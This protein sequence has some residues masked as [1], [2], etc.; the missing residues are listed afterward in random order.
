M[1][2]PFEKSDD[3]HYNKDSIV[4]QKEKRRIQ[5]M[6]P[7]NKKRYHLIDSIRGLTLVS[8]ILYHAVWNLVYLYGHNWY[9][10]QSEIGY[11]WQ[12][13]ICYTLI[14]FSGFCWS[15]GKH[16]LKRG[17]EVLLCG[18]L[19]TAVTLL[20]MPENRVVFGVLTLIGSCMIL[21]CPLHKLFCKLPAAFGFFCSLLL[22]VLLRNVNGGFLGFEGWNL[23]P[24]PQQM[25]TGMVS[26]YFGFPHARFFSTDYFSLFPWFFLYCTG[27]FSFQLAARHDLLRYFEAPRC[28][29]AEWIG[30]H[31]LELYLLHQPV[32]LLVMELTF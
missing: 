26:A 32:L 1:I 24:L 9:W 5:P 16:P 28:L 18:L 31:S 21:L 11:V 29:P 19:I 6:N 13:S 14:L 23:L 22:F 15:F 8:M 25:Y 30:R 2:L 17:M 12:Q 10:Y 20:A 4:I 27:Y 7:T 3:F